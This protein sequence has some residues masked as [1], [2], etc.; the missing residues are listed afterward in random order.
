MMLCA[1]NY[2]TDKLIRDNSYSKQRKE[3]DDKIL[4][5]FFLLKLGSDT[6]Y[7][8]KQDD[9]GSRVCLF[10][11]REF[12]IMSQEEILREI[13]KNEYFSLILVNTLKKD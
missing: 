13:L 6:C 1:K 10:S 12:N 4:F 3:T 11:E 8:I 7:T 9:G 5:P 2:F